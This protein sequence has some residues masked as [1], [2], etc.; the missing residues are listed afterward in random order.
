MTTPAEAVETLR[1]AGL[2]E[3]T[4]A[5][6]VGTRQSTINKIRRGLMNPTYAVGK[7]LVDLAE[8]IGSD[9]CEVKS[10]A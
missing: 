7:A 2:T 4:I 3:A 6:R 8:Q 10:A 9:D 5:A 1:A